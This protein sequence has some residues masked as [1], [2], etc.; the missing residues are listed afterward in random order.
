MKGSILINVPGELSAPTK[1]GR[2]VSAD[3]VYD[4]EMSMSQE[5]VNKKTKSDIDIL[6]NFYNASVMSHSI[7]LTIKDGNDDDITIWSGKLSWES[8]NIMV[9]SS[10]IE[11]IYHYASS[12]ETYLFIFS[13]PVSIIHSYGSTSSLTLYSEANTS[14]KTW[15]LSF[16]S[17][18]ATTQQWSM[19]VIPDGGAVGNLAFSTYYYVEPTEEPTE[20]PT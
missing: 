7:D 11:E 2:V 18:S 19:L 12:P 9:P 13:A 4:Y 14:R 15:T 3:G 8:G 6:K 16:T 10:S 5:D 1:E 17:P 20:A